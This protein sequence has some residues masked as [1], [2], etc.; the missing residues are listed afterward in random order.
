MK[1]NKTRE[2][3]LALTYFS[4]LSSCSSCSKKEIKEEKSTCLN[5][6]YGDFALADENR[7]DIT[8]DTETIYHMKTKVIHRV[9]IV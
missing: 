2:L 5:E 3:L 4:I 8:P 9:Y 7:Y 1:K 6:D